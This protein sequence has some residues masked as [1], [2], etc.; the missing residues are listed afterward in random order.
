MERDVQSF[1]HFKFVLDLYYLEDLLYK[2]TR[3]DWIKVEIDRY[4]NFTNRLATR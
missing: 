1:H 2:F 4:G 3:G